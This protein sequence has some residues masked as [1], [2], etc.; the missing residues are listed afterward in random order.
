MATV[1]RWSGL[2]VRALREASR[3]STEEFAARLGVGDRMV[4]RWEAR[5]D[6]IRLKQVNQG[7]LGHP[8]RQ[9]LPRHP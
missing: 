5:K 7:R 8:P 9:L 1:G 4:S 2:E 6:T 3:M